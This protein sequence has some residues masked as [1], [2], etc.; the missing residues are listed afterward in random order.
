MFAVGQIV[1]SAC[2]VYLL[3]H[4][5]RESFPDKLD[6]RQLFGVETNGSSVLESF[7][8]YSAEKCK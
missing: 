4:M 1:K 6:G 3:D 5:E 7:N 2:H 8:G